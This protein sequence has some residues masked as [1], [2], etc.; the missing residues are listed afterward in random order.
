LAAV[1]AAQQR[2][3]FRVCVLALKLVRVCASSAFLWLVWVS[4]RAC[5]GLNS[6]VLQ[7]FQE[8]LTFSSLIAYAVI[9][10]LADE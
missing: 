4:L 9:E 2:L 1:L 7:A 5:V 3:V 8:P 10:D 6:N